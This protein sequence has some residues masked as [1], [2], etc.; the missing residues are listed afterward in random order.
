MHSW[1]RRVIGR[2]RR[3]EGAPLWRVVVDSTV[4]MVIV[5]LEIEA[6]ETRNGPV[7]SRMGFASALLYTMR[8]SSFWK[9]VVCD[10]GGLCL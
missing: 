4:T 3:W 2:S 8:V 1:T 7:E 5:Q 9:E 6:V 10:G